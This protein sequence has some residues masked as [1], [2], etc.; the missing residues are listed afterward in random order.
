VI[1]FTLAVFALA[2]CLVGK[3]L[4]EHLRRQIAGRDAEVLHAVSQMQQLVGDAEIDGDS[5]SNPASQFE[6]VLRTSQLQGLVDSL[7]GVLAARLFGPDGRFIV[8]SALDI[9][10][11]RLS[12]E[13]LE[14]LKKLRPVS[15]WYGHALPS[16]LFITAQESDSTPFPLLVVN[17][18]LQ[19]K[20]Q[21]AL[22]GI[23]QFVL[24]GQSMKAEFAAL[25]R[26][27][28]QQALWTFLAG[29]VIM[30]AALGLVF[31]GLQRSNRLLAERT[32]S[33]LRAN[34]EL[35]LAAKTSAVGA[36]TSHLIHGLK[37]PLSGLQSYVT[38]RNGGH[39][40][41]TEWIEAMATTARMQSLISE[42][43]RLLQEQLV[44]AQYEVSLFEMAELVSSKA[45][46]VARKAQVQFKHEVRGQAVLRNHEA[47][48][49]ALILDN[50]VANSLHATP[51]GKVVSLSIV[52]E[53]GGTVCEV[54]DQGTG[55]PAG[56]QE[57]L[58]T[59]GLSAKNGGSGIGL[60]ISKRL[61]EHLGG[62]LELATTNASGSV[63]RLTLPSRRNFLADA[64]TIQT[65]EEESLP[66]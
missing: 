28:L 13:D 46:P 55:L 25:D 42:V 38:N 23:A 62:V 48:L 63:F 50:L 65:S 18:P 58:F 31:H 64:A 32:A 43:V 15:H 14:G 49:I 52:A 19:A 37:N 27:L 51:P 56:I 24:D 61:A 39:S 26:N 35:T 3:N 57:N 44:G 66:A 21:K 34:H 8:A 6:L 47:N 17:I 1:G 11:S 30:V 9:T 4:R 10:E 20:N 41:D 53:Q 2:L 40:P 12:A 33:L 7:Q 16:D 59:P 45:I 60:A 5:Q 29:S 54:S 22:A 36:V